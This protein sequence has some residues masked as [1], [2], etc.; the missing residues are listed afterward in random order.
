MAEQAI[1]SKLTDAFTSMAKQAIAQQPGA[2]T[3]RRSLQSQD[4]KAATPGGTWREE[5]PWSGDKWGSEKDTSEVPREK[6]PPE[7]AE[8][9]WKEDERDRLP[10]RDPPGRS[11]GARSPAPVRY[12]GAQ[13]A[14]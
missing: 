11:A 7:L 2:E 14:N 1:T 10:R 5:K 4:P 9:R 13:R 8:R 12:Q 3:D 6:R